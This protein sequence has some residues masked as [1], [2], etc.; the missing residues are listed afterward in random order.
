MEYLFG[1]SPQE[2]ATTPKPSRPPSIVVEESTS[3]PDDPGAS[4]SE[5]DIIG[6]AHSTPFVIT[7]TPVRTPEQSVV[8]HPWHLVHFDGL[9]QVSSLPTEESVDLTSREISPSTSVFNSPAFA[10]RGVKLENGSS[11]H[12]NVPSCTDLS[13]PATRVRLVFVREDVSILFD[14]PPDSTRFQLA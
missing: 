8:H 4:N 6:T 9:S 1:S 7:R 13:S 11:L 2:A 14:A 12:S 5:H 3:I 10:T